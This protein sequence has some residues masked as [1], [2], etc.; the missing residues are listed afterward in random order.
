MAFVEENKLPYLHV[1]YEGLIG[2]PEKNIA[3]LN[4]FLDAKLTIDQL[5]SVYRGP[6]HRRPV[7]S[8]SGVAKAVLIYLKNYSE[9]ADVKDPLPI[10]R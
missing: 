10:S 6:L 1:T 8:V 7:S 2:E 4:E 9:R 3:R 5:A